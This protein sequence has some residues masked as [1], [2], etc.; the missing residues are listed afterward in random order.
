VHHP[1]VGTPLIRSRWFPYVCIAAAVLVANAPGLLHLVDTNPLDLDAFLVTT[2]P[3]WLPGAPTADPNAGFLM[4]ALGHLVSTDWLSGHIPWWNPYEGIGTPLAGDMQSGAFFP[5]TFLF[6]LADGMV[7]FQV[8]LE[9]IAGWCTY[10][11]LV[12]LEIGRTLATAGGAAFALCGTFAW[13]AIEPIRV[14]C[15]LPLCLL[16]VERLLS[17][18]EDERPWGWRLLAVGLAGSFLAGYPE[19]FAIDVLFVAGWA[20]ARMLG[21]GRGHV[22]A[23]AGKLAAAAGAA[24]ALALPLVVAFL[25]YLR[26]ADTG[27]HGAGGFA[28]ATLPARSLA[29][30]ILPYSA[31]PIDAF[32][33]PGA[34]DTLSAF[35]GSVGGYLDATLLAAALVG[36]VGRRNRILRL[37]LVAWVAVCLARTYGFAPVVDVLAHV[38]GLRLTAF[39][40]YADP[41]WE[42]AAVVLAALGLDDIAG[43][44]TRWTALAAAVAVAGV[45]AAAAAWEGYRTLT[46]AIGPTGSAELHRH[47]FAAGSLVFALATLT[48]LLVGGWLAAGRLRR[49]R[50]R[51]GGARTPGDARSVDGGTRRRWGRVAMAMAVS[52]EAVVLLGVTYLSAPR[53]TT[54]DTGSVTWMQAHL[55]TYRFATLGPI[56]PNYGSYYRI[57]EVNANEL[58]LPKAWTRYVATR[59]DGNTVPFEFTGGYSSDP[60]GPT[61]AQEFS[62]HLS[63]FEA[64]GVRYVVVAASGLDPTGS[65]FPAP[66]TPAGPR[67][68]H[69][70]RWAEIW[71]LPR[72]APAFSVTDDA[73]CRVTVLGWDAARVTCARPT[74]LIRR[75]QAAPGWS[76]DVAG[77]TVAVGTA[78]S[79]PPGLFQAVAVPA[80]T[81]TVRF[82]YLPPG[83]QWAVPVGVLAWLAL[84]GSVV[85]TARARRRRT[86]AAPP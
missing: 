69:R 3:R 26:F 63:A 75:V 35:W 62:R 40:R 14:L 22:R 11:L 50:H 33:T 34:V 28:K 78:R 85:I 18:A 58:P 10:A 79:G 4:Q 47:R 59:L 31:G 16:G 81:T 23:M 60:T 72:P 80:G 82:H 65:R 32:H 44:R 56:Q 29:Q 6:G 36:A 68:V 42:L 64:V 24:L 9:L 51:M 71:Q 76:A 25:G 41:T 55:G 84:A 19:T 73:G 5:P 8:T 52:V 12:R 53:P 86:L 13:F 46:P 1:G 37:A 77:S 38:P 2:V 27:A 7:W 43:R 66:G 17:A 74:V 30:L 48:L 21:P 49:P 39:Y 15:L 83:E 54:A 57:A 67:L 61:P 45:A 20:A 70:D